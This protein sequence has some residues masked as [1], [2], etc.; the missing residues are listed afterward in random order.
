[1]PIA[2][3][4]LLGVLLAIW[5]P[6]GWQ[7][8]AAWVVG[9]VTAFS[10]LSPWWRP[11]LLLA[12]GFFLASHAAG[13][14]LDGQVLC[15]DRVLAR[16]QIVSVPER[17]PG[18][19][20]FDARL[21]LLHQPA[22][23]PVMVRVSGSGFV[24]R[25]QPGETWQ[26][27]LQLRGASV[28]A[29]A[30]SRRR[31][32]LRD[33]VSIEAR[34]LDSPLSYRLGVADG[35]LLATRQHIASRI[36]R[37]VADPAAAALLAALAVGVTADVS[38]QQWRAFSATGITHL[39]AISGMHVTFL[40]MLCMAMA[41][42]IWAW[43]PPLAVRTRREVFAGAVGVVMATAYALLSGF[44]VPAQR[45]LVML[46]AFLC[47]RESGRA[48][49][50]LWSVAIAL[51]AVLFF[52]PL[53]VLSAGFWLSFL[54][55]ASIIQFAGARL[56]P[57]GTLRSATSVQVIVSVALMPLTLLL[58]GTFST[59][60]LLVNALAIPVFTFLLVPPMLLA[61]V[62]YLIPAD[63]TQWIADRLVDLA[64]MAAG[65]G[66][67]LLAVVA[68]HEASML[69]ATPVAAW[70][71]LCIPA[72]VLV[73]MP[74]RPLLRATGAILLLLVVLMRQSGPEAGE[75]WVDVLDVGAAT[76]AIVS[77]EK[78]RLIFGA[79][80]VFGSR[81]QRFEERVARPLLETGGG[82]AD[83]VVAGRLNRDSLRAVVAADAL[84][85][86]ALVI[87][88]A[89][90]IGPPEI[91]ACSA[92]SWNW[93]GV[94]FQLSA[95]PAG[96]SCVLAVNAGPRRIVLSQEGVDAGPSDWMLLPR[97][98]R[99]QQSAQ[100][101]ASL[102]TGGIVVASTDQREWQASRW[103]EL[104]DELEGEGIHLRSTA[105]TGALHFE[106]SP[107][108]RVWMRT[109]VLDPGIWM[110]L[111]RDRSCAGL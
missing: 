66:Y 12:L 48:F 64:A 65:R 39:V 46:V 88:N 84:L 37:R 4:L 79:G 82:H 17:Q 30:G 36:D 100:I 29:G 85:D 97:N 13:K 27:A 73:V 75:L 96:N 55:V 57:G 91:A 35:S 11:A 90:S 33:R 87:R 109:R 76:A 28:K 59:S 69:H 23:P 102:R 60:G 43:A 42:R 25:P 56:H 62:G 78:H 92:R 49:G 98:V 15:E 108:G 107:R 14:V 72:V 41:R 105:E 101:R 104:K 67:P 106:F 31:A 45:T 16:G 111:P 21:R 63:S 44:S 61:T 18:G 103:R 2:F 54:A 51:L 24:A 26:L 77:T 99:S 3:S 74:L 20:R 10:L 40:A 81:G 38:R 52:D 94:R 22:R 1:M 110:R 89:G 8:E 95:G 80:E 93:D 71:L 32:L 19:W 58:F 50:T 83:I 53:A 34:M 70:Y 7:S 47:A 86:A 68:D 6:A 5:L 9:F